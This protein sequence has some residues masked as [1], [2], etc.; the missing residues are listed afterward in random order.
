LPK[1]KQVKVNTTVGKIET[2]G[3]L[4]KTTFSV[5]ASAHFFH[6]I[7]STLYTRPIHAIVRELSCNAFDSHT[8]NGNPET[9]FK[10]CLP[11]ALR[12]QFS[13]QDYGVGLSPAQIKEVYTVVFK[14]DKTNSN[15]FTGAF[16]LGSKSPF[17]YTDNFTIE[18]VFDGRKYIYKAYKNEEGVPEVAD[19]SQGGFEVDECSGVKIS[20]PVEQR[21]FQNFSDA[22]LHQLFYF[23]VTPEVVGFSSWGHREMPNFKKKLEAGTYCVNDCDADIFQTNVINNGHHGYGRRNNNFN[24][25]MGNVNYTLDFKKVP[26]ELTQLLQNIV[27]NE[28]F[29]FVPIGSVTPAA[30]REYLQYDDKTVAFIVDKLKLVRDKEDTDKGSTV[31]ELNKTFTEG[32]RF[33]NI[34]KISNF[35]TRWLYADSRHSAVFQQQA[36]EIVP[37]DKTLPKKMLF[38]NYVNFNS[39]ELK[40][41]SNLLFSMVDKL[42]SYEIDKNYPAQTPQGTRDYERSTAN[43]LAFQRVCNFLRSDASKR[44]I[45]IYI[46]KTSRGLSKTAFRDHERRHDDA[47]YQILIL[48]ERLDL[49]QDIQKHFPAGMVKIVDLFEPRE[50]KEKDEDLAEDAVKYPRIDSDLLNISTHHKFPS[51]H[52]DVRYNSYSY[53]IE[54]GG[55]TAAEVKE[56]FRGKQV[57]VFGVYRNNVVQPNGRTV[58]GSNFFEKIEDITYVFVKA[59]KL[60]KFC[61]FFNVTSYFDFKNQVLEELVTTFK[62]RVGSEEVNSVVYS[63]KNQPTP[64]WDSSGMK[65]FR[66]NMPAI[67]EE[68]EAYGKFS[69]VDLETSEL[70]FFLEIKELTGKFSIYSERSFISKVFMDLDLNWFPYNRMFYSDNAEKEYGNAIL[71]IATNNLLSKI[72]EKKAVDNNEIV[73]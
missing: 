67:S 29:M 56:H 3:Q 39:A 54:S 12:P 43:S 48:R 38:G 26:E 21:D 44:R 30:S 6:I 35:S 27:A 36:V 42:N 23:D 45:E 40:N 14:S 46:S 20:F 4:D 72:K 25:I 13:V 41:I 17:A 55:K 61:E 33:D 51:L 11:T 10:V 52:A 53:D 24:I 34:L 15:D 47:L 7:S 2:S 8:K 57:L 70:N 59:S 22:A 18:S 65:S 71:E 19:M 37:L 63:I 16:G 73:S 62:E 28:V 5:D 69:F 66:D 60:E 1:G 31:A 50:K 68:L 58:D 9:P 49:A 64:F 32:D